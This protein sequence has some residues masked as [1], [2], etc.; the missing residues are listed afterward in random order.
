M[1]LF[2]IILIFAEILI[3]NAENPE[4]YV[5]DYFL[6]TKLGPVN[7]FVAQLSPDFKAD[8]FLGIPF[9]KAPVEVLRF[10][11]PQPVGPWTT[12]LQAKTMPKGC[13]PHD[14]SGLPE[15]LFSDDCLYLNIF[16]PHNQSSKPE[17]GYPVLVWVHGGGYEVGA[18]FFYGYKDISL[19]FA[20]QDIIVVTIQYR[21]GFTGFSSTGDSVMPGNLGYWDQTAAFKFLKENIKEFGGDENNIVA[22]GLSAGGA[23]TAALSIAPASRGLISKSIEMSGAVFANWHAGEQV[24]QVTAKLSEALG[25]PPISESSKLKKCFKSKT[26][27]EFLE[28]VKVIGNA[29]YGVNLVKFHPRIDG[30]F[31]PADFPELIKTA[32]KKPTMMGFTDQEAA[33]FT[34]MGQSKTLNAFGIPRESFSQYTLKNFTDAVEQIVAPKKIFGSKAPELQKKIIDFY[35]KDFEKN[36]EGF[37]GAYSNL[38]S[39]LWFTIPGLWTAKAKTES[40]WPVYLYFNDYYNKKMFGKEIPVKGSMHANEYPY[41]FGIFPV[42]PFEFDDDDRKAQKV[43]VDTIVQFS[44]KSN[45]STESFTWPLTT[46]ENPFINA[47]IRP[48]PFVQDSLLKENLEFWNQLTEEYDFNIVRGIHKESRKTKDEL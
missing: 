29:R 22:F 5:E 3:S 21:L 17:S 43:I 44:K 34:I 16:R 6:R 12:P 4:G 42:A 37:L 48:E 20:T 33:Y 28:A 14:L 15:T 36:Y 25:C 19:N 31:F 46:P 23:S 40:G 24:V 41:M 7:G 2:S 26:P 30:D 13:Y 18:T 45:P 8:I 10:E 39:D 32:P 1:K 35:L 9:A 11:K 38:F 47:V 27:K